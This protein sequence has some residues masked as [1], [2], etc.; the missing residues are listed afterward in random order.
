MI[1]QRTFRTP[2]L[3]IRRL[4]IGSGSRRDLRQEVDT[5]LREM[6]FVLHLTERVK[7]SMMLHRR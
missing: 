4:L 6:A 7:A 3:P 5:H 1:A 2:S